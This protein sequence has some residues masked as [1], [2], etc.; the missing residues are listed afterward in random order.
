MIKNI[1]APTPRKAGT[2]FEKPAKVEKSAKR[3]NST[4]LINLF[5][6]I[7]EMATPRP[8]SR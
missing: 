4:F 6:F 1:T 3:S 2:G 5:G 7:G 8:R